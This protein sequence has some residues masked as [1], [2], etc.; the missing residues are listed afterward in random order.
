M[1]AFD[2]LGLIGTL[3]VGLAMVILG[4]LSRRFGAATRAAPRYRGFY[5][6]SGFLFVSATLQLLNF[7]LA[8][9]AADALLESPL[10]LIVYNILPAVGVTIGLFHTWH[11]WSWLLAESG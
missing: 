9:T 6:A 10:W 3:G 11:Y 4:L 5:I 7:L 1:S 8:H 2:G